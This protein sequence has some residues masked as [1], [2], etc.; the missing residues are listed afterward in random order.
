MKKKPVKKTVKVTKGYFD[1]EKDR[2]RAIDLTVKG[3][4]EGRGTPENLSF[5][6]V[7]T[8]GSDAIR[9]ATIERIVIKFIDNQPADARDSLVTLLNNSSPLA[10]L[11]FTVLSQS[12]SFDQESFGAAFR[13]AWIENEYELP[14]DWRLVVD[15]VIAHLETLQSDCAP[16]VG[17]VVPRAFTRDECS[18]M[19]HTASH[20]M[21]WL[22]I[23]RQKYLD[24]LE[25][26]ND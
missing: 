17:H 5:L 3:V 14:D 19:C 2:Q 7:N 24:A 15:G 20:A 16:I 1:P 9:N 23:L 22:K 18:V 26:N 25:C 11:K 21:F 8:C 10:I 12:P 13:D 4:M 6:Y